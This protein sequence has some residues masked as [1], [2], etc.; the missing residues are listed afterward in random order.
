MN[1]A[2]SGDI[3]TRQTLSQL[4]SPPSFEGADANPFAYFLLRRNFSLI[5]CQADAL[6]SQVEQLTLGRLLFL[7]PFSLQPQWEFQHFH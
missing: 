7:Y 6:T 4:P 3:S 1:S 5:R 2:F